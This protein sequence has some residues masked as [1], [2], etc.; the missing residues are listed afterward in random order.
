M[1]LNRLIQPHLILVTSAYPLRYTAFLK[2]FVLFSLALLIFGCDGK[3]DVA[4]PFSVT[5]TASG[6]SDDKLALNKAATFTAEVSDYEGDLSRLSYRWVLSTERGELSDDTNALSN[7]TVG[8][9]SIRCIGKSGGDEKIIVEVLDGTN[10]IVA[11]SSYAFT[12]VP[13]D[14]API[15]RGCFDQPKFI[16]S[17]GN[18][19]YVMNVDGTGQEY[20][21]ISG[22]GFSIVSPDGEWYAWT[23]YDWDF[24]GTGGWD[25]HVQ[26]C[27]G[28]DRRKIEGGTGED[29]QVKFSPDSKTLYF[30]RPDPEQE[31][32]GSWGRLLDIVAYDMESEDLRFLTSFYKDG[33]QVRDFT[34]NPLTGEIAF[35]HQK[36]ESPPEGG[37]RNIYNRFSFLQPASGLIT[38][39]T[40]ESTFPHDG[41]DWSPDGE[42]IIFAGASEESGRGLY[43]IDVAEGSKAMLLYPYTDP[44]TVQDSPYFYYA[45]GSRIAFRG[46]D[47]PNVRT[48]WSIDANGNDLQKIPDTNRVAF[49][50]GVLH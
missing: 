20:L 21:G 9:N 41:M 46:T 26:R 43:R 27:D 35:F 23:I 29:F 18:S 44:N 1:K 12:I 40:D 38:Y 7:P 39:T 10:S 22:D 19:H 2:V 48:L 25:M 11:M 42:D 32:S 5:I 8:G 4:Y 15:S 34:V 36:A 45:G 28:S 6:L 14:D 47:G 13:P 3:E 17:T 33:A 24:E 31:F 50:M 30:L 49:F 37:T 16:Y